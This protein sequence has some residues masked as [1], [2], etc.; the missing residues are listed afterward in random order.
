MTNIPFERFNVS[1]F[2]SGPYFY[3]FTIFA[4]IFYFIFWDY[5]IF[6]SFSSSK[7]LPH[8]LTLFVSC[9]TYIFMHM[10]MYIHKYINTTYTICIMLS[11]YR[12]LGLTFWH[13]IMHFSPL[14]SPSHHFLSN[15]LFFCV[16]IVIHPERHIWINIEIKLAE[17]ICIHIY[18][19]LTTVIG[20]TT[21][22]PNPGKDYSAFLSSY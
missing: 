6:S 22:W 7:T 9:F 12:L 10:Y 20:Y 1:Q 19:W 14:S 8:F 15:G 3:L 4:F 18:I 21:R 13:S 17:S 2:L 16:C 5:I 11:V